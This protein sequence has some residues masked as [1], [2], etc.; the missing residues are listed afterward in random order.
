MAM[1][2]ARAHLK[3]LGRRDVDVAS[4]GLTDRYSP[5]GSPADP[6]AAR[7]LAKCAGLRS[8]GHESRLL[9]REELDA[10]A[11][12]FYVTDEHARR[13]ASFSVRKTTTW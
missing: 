7:A 1:Q 10:C 3:S 4:R 5:W 13:A 11:A 2:M 6:R 12:C 8:D 9:R